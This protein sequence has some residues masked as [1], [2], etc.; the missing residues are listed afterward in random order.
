MAILAHE[1]T[2]WASGHVVA[3]TLVTM[4][5]APTVWTVN[6]A[7]WIARHDRDGTRGALLGPHPQL[8]AVSKRPTER[9]QFGQLTPTEP[10]RD[11]ECR[12]S[13]RD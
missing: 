4:A 11:A 10:T 5:A 8:A 1:L 13:P 2:H 3:T 6:A 7:A 9:C 12:V